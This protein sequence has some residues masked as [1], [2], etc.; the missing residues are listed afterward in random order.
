MNSAEEYPC[1]TKYTGA[2]AAPSCHFHQSKDAGKRYRSEAAPLSTNHCLSLLHLHRRSNPPYIPAVSSK[3]TPYAPLCRLRHRRCRDGSNCLA[4]ND[5]LLPGSPL[6]YLFT[7]LFGQGS[8]SILPRPL[9][10][11]CIWRIWELKEQTR[12]GTGLVSQKTK[13]K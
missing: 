13:R 7:A 9:G 3:A 5:L 4:T 2:A 1:W 6:L 11:T 8:F 12:S 10:V